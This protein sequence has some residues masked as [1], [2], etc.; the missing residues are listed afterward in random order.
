[1]VSAPFHF[2]IWLG[3]IAFFLG[4]TNSCRQTESK[5]IYRENLSVAS[6]IPFGDSDPFSNHAG[7]GA[8]ILEL[9]YPVL[10]RLNA[11]GE[12]LLGLAEGIEWSQT[13]PEIRLRLKTPDADAIVATFEK[14]KKLSGIHFL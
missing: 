11:A 13:A 9:I 4:F 7:I 2:A 3:I 1:M 10:F 14:V 6:G 12:P 5:K 8:N